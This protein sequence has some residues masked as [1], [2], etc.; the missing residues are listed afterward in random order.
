MGVLSAAERGG[1]GYVPIRN[2]DKPLPEGEEGGWKRKLSKPPTPR[3][4]VGLPDQWDMHM[5]KWRKGRSP[6]EPRR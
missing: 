6:V 2:K 4:L 1:R 5:E 3:G